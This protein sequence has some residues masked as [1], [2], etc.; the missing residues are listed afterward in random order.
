MN[1]YTIKT[2]LKAVNQICETLDTEE[3]LKLELGLTELCD[4]SKY[5]QIKFWG[6]IR[7]EKSHYYIAQALKIK[8]EF[9]FPR[10]KFFYATDNFIFKELPPLIK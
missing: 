2:D 9:E 5:D 4:S 6:R 7:G 1:I 8:N 3:R 10:K